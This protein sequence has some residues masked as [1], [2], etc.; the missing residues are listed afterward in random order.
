MLVFVSSSET[1]VFSLTKGRQKY[2]NL[3]VNPSIAIS[4][5]DSDNPYRY[6]GLRGALTSVEDDSS[7]SFIDSMAKKYMRRATS[8]RWADIGSDPNS[9]S[10]TD[11][12]ANGM[13]GPF[14]DLARSSCEIRRRDHES[15][16]VRWY[17]SLTSR[18][19]MRGY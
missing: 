2:E 18:R 10:R 7:N 4:G 12:R 1:F 5:I 16:G 13:T 3:A 15:L 9:G 8:P 19:E 14:P 6:L 11:R 17:A